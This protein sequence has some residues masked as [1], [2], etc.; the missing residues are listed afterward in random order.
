MKNQTHCYYLQDE[1]A[2]QQV[3]SPRLLPWERLKVFPDT[4]PNPYLTTPSHRRHLMDT[5]GD[6]LRHVNKL[7]NKRYGHKPRKVPAHIPHM[8][9]KNIMEQLQ[10]RYGPSLCHSLSTWLF[11]SPHRYPGEFELTSSHKL[12]SSDDMQFA[13]SYFY[14]MMSEKLIA[15]YS[16]IFNEL[17]TDK[18]GYGLTHTN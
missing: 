2:G 3:E 7:F 16:A 15:N 1:W 6:S 11:F 5:F 13:F 18:T 17:D 8:I 12:R 14:F 9:N 10:E 4:R